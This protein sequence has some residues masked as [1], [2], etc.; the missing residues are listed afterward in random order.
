MSGGA[1]IGRGEAAAPI[2]SARPA[3]TRRS[4]GSA[5]TVGTAS[6][7]QCAARR[8]GAARLRMSIRSS[9]DWPCTGTTSMSTPARDAKRS[10]SSGLVPFVETRAM[11]MPSGTAS[12]SRRR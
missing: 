6:T 3:V 5:G 12:E 11:T 4:A 1:G 10:S 9:N 8:S 7:E 2:L